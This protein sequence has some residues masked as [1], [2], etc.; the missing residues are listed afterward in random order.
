MNNFSLPENRFKLNLPLLENFNYQKLNEEIELKDKKND[1]PF[2]EDT[3]NQQDPEPNESQKLRSEIMKNVQKDHYYW[4]HPVP[5]NN[6]TNIDDYYYRW[7]LPPSNFNKDSEIHKVD[8]KVYTFQSDRNKLNKEQL[9]SVWNTRSFEVKSEMPDL[10]HKWE[11][12][13]W[14][15]HSWEEKRMFLRKVVAFCWRL[16]FMMINVLNPCSE[17][18]VRKGCLLALSKPNLLNVFVSVWGIIL[19]ILDFLIGLKFRTIQAGYRNEVEQNVFRKEYAKLKLRESELTNTCILLE[20]LLIPNLDVKKQN[21]KKY[22]EKKAIVESLQNKLRQASVK[23]NADFTKKLKE[24]KNKEDFEEEELEIIRKE[25]D[26]KR[27]E[28][29]YEFIESNKEKFDNK[30]ILNLLT[31]KLKTHHRYAKL[32]EKLL[33]EKEKLRKKEYE[34]LKKQ[35]P[36]YSLIPYKLKNLAEKNIA[37]KEEALRGKMFQELMEYLENEDH[38]EEIVLLKNHKIYQNKKKQ[39]FE[40]ELALYRPYNLKPV[41]TMRVTIRL[42]QSCYKIQDSSNAY[43]PSFLLKKTKDVDISSSFFGYK[44]VFGVF[45]YLIDVYNTAYYLLRWIWD[46][47]FSLRV[48]FGCSDYYRNEDIDYK[49][50]QYSREKRFRMRPVVR[51]FTAILKGMSLYKKRFEESPDNGFFGKN[52]A[53]VCL[54]LECFIIRFLL[55]GVIFILI[56]YPLLIFVS[57]AITL[58]LV[59][60]SVVWVL[61][62][63]LLLLAWKLIIFDYNSTLSGYSYVRN[64][65]DKNIFESGQLILINSY[66]CL[67]LALHSLDIFFQIILQSIICCC[68]LLI[69]PLLSLASLFGGVLLFIIKTIWDWLILNLIIRCCARVPSRDTGYAMRVSGP[70][71]SRDFYNSLESQHLSLLV[72]AQL[73]R[74]ELR[75]LQ[76]EVKD[77][78]EH[79]RTVIRDK[80]RALFKDL[81]TLPDNGVYISK[82]FGNINYL[83]Q[84]I[85]HHV[86]KRLLELPTISSGVHTVRFT[87]E[88]LEKNQLIIQSLLGE[89]IEEKEMDYYIWKNYDLRKGLFKR[90]TRKILKE[91]LTNDALKAVEQV[92]QVQRVKY[93][94]SS[95][96]DYV[97]KVV[98]NEENVYNMKFKKKLQLI[99]SRRRGIRN[100]GNTYYAL[101]SLVDYF[102]TVNLVYVHPFRYYPVNE[103]E[104]KDWKKIYLDNKRKQ[105]KEDE[106]LIR[107]D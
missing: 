80:Y 99:E 63:N 3:S 74:V 41:K 89:V 71:I 26:A 91:I 84:S 70:G 68:I 87:K 15:I 50:G 104:I 47:P 73:E 105:E 7:D 24:E 40:R 21:T 12:S 76:Q 97:K 44:F 95:I 77:I 42:F 22:L 69:N 96:N 81:V 25:F 11:L 98:M 20:Y 86:N 32:D 23:F 36:I 92:D 88:D 94:K 101:E 57:M 79:P 90:L 34:D 103:R 18:V 5:E 49:T 9:K 14:L 8:L 19:N 13:P 35:Y 56:G 45:S 102:S 59:V 83:K 58:I 2:D 75:Q 28:M 51:Q 100:K 55:I 46:G 66:R 93:S 67:P 31:K 61:A 39:L 37:A 16:F 17:R 62:F 72:I 106:N 38:S 53:R 85:D 82:S 65:S 54:Y 4:N 78:L 29:L 64:N 1:N 48:L 33:E 6:Q 107:L 52:M 30:E 27:Q 43:N 60:T 10:P